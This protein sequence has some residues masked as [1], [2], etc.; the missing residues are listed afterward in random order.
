MVASVCCTQSLP[1]DVD[2]LL[3]VM[4]EMLSVLELLLEQAEPQLD[5][6]SGVCVGRRTVTAVPVRESTNGASTRCG[7]WRGN[8][9]ASVGSCVRWRRTSRPC[10]RTCMRWCTGLATLVTIG[11]VCSVRAL[12]LVDGPEAHNAAGAFACSSLVSAPLP[13]CP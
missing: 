2:S 3:E 1:E 11:F 5:D 4:L 8:A 9:K 7:G 6:A 13:V 10:I 12:A